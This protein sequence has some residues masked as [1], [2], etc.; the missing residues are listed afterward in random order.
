ML[1]VVG[2]EVVADDVGVGV[3]LGVG[4]N[5]EGG[6]PQPATSNPSDAIANDPRVVRRTIT[7]FSSGAGGSLVIIAV[8]VF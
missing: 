5:S 4:L 8:A 1:L 6:V 2:V 3:A 7:G